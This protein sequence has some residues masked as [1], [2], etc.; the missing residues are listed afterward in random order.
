V[1]PFNPFLQCNSHNLR[2]NLQKKKR[3]KERKSPLLILRV[4]E[5]H[6]RVLRGI[7]IMMVV[8]RAAT[9][10]RRDIYVYIIYMMERERVRERG[11][12][13]S[14]GH[15]SLCARPST[16]ELSEQKTVILH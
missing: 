4:F 6:L 16:T 9:G 13:R 14:L 3:K 10:G 7:N 5:F 1:A 12:C 15:F 11:G 2:K 8:R